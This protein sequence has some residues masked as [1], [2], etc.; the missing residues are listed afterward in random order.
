MRKN[1][2]VIRKTQREVERERGDLE[3]QEK[4]LVSSNSFTVLSVM[5]PARLPELISPWVCFNNSHVRGSM[6]KCHLSDLLHTYVL[7]LQVEHRPQITCLHPAL[8]CAAASIFLQLYLYP[9]V[10]I[11]FSRSLLQ[12]FLGR[13]HRLWPSDVHCSTCLVMLSSFLLNVCPSQFHL[14]LYIWFSTSWPVS[15][16][17]FVNNSVWPVY[18]AKDSQTFIDENL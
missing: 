4:K 7:L 12:V 1:D 9:A 8:S 16:L 13:P 2:R 14:L 18:I 3:R 17:F 10:H 6:W 15:P 5:L 11:S